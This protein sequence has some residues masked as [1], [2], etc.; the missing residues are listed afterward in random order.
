MGSRFKPR[1][2][3]NSRSCTNILA[4]LPPQVGG[5]A[6]AYYMATTVLAVILGIILVTA[7]RPGDAA[8]KGDGDDIQGVRKHPRGCQEHKKLCQN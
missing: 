8:K 7:I 2:H 4:I 5:R 1:S 6:V 3:H